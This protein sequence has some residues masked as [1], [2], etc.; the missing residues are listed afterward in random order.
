MFVC[1]TSKN[2]QEVKLD[3]Y[4][5]NEHYGEK[6]MNWHSNGEYRFAGEVFANGEWK[7]RVIATDFDGSKENWDLFFKYP[8]E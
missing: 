6:P 7:I 8:F 5:N 1:K 2:I 3:I 4:L